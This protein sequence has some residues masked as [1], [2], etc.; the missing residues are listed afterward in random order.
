MTL[1]LSHQSLSACKDGG[2]REYGL[3]KQPQN[4]VNVLNSDSVIF[5]QPNFVSLFHYPFP[6]KYS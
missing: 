6:F 2:H 4:A 3:F 1:I 5:T